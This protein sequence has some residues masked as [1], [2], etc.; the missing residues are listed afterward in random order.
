MSG[1]PEDWEREERGYPGMG[2]D[3]LEE[4]LIDLREDLDEVAANAKYSDGCPSCMRPTAERGALCA[5]C[6]QLLAELPESDS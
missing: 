3:T 5:H 2:Y 4:R 1:G 6:Q